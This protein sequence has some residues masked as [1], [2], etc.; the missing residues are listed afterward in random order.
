M[1]KSD[2]RVA[3]D[4]YNWLSK[5]A[6]E[7]SL[8]YEY[9]LLFTRNELEQEDVA[10]FNHEFL[11]SMGISVAKHRLEILKLARKEVGENP[12]SISR[13]LLAIK[14]AKK[15]FSKWVFRGQSA[16]RAM[17]DLAPFRAHW[18]GALRKYKSSKEFSNEKVA[19]TN[20]RTLKSGPL[21]STVQGSLMVTAGRSLQSVSG[22]LDRDLQERMTSI[23]RSPTASVPPGG[24]VLQERFLI[25]NK[26]QDEAWHLDERCLSPKL[27]GFHGK[28]KMI[29]G[30]EIQPLW[31]IMFQDMKP[32]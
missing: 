8:V 14:Q 9:G 1:L 21:D 10:A 12:Q 5:T 18:T 22:P 27:N 32:T 13:L 24:R 23:N 2:H 11:Q 28:G 25:A 3:M 4:W 16:G 6:L 26:H 31:S 19:I 17:S 20:R 7:R 30:K 15:G 29:A